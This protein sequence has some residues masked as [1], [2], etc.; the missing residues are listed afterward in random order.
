MHSSPPSAGKACCDSPNPKTQSRLRSRLH[1]TSPWPPPATGASAQSAAA[2]RCATAG[3]RRGG[4]CQPSL[5]GLPWPPPL[6]RRGVGAAA[7]GAVARGVLAAAPAPAS[8]AAAAARL[9]LRVLTVAVAVVVVHGAGVVGLRRGFLVVGAPAAPA[10][11]TSAPACARLGRGRGPLPGLAGLVHTQPGRR[12]EIHVAGRAG[13]VGAHRAEVPEDVVAAQGREGRRHARGE[14]QQGSHAPRA[15][16]VRLAEQPRQ[17]A[18][19]LLRRL[20][21]RRRGGLL[22][23]GVVRGPGG[24]LPPDLRRRRR[25]GRRPGR[26]RVRP[27]GRRPRAPG[28]LDGLVQVAALLQRPPEQRLVE[29]GVLRVRVGPGR[30]P[31]W[32][33]L[34]RTRSALGRVLLA[35]AV[36]HLRGLLLLPQLLGVNIVEALEQSLQVAVPHHLDRGLLQILEFLFFDLVLLLD[37]LHLLVGQAPQVHTEEVIVV[38]LLCILVPGSGALVH[39]WLGRA[40]IVTL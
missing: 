11:A 37:L 40:D 2:P 7:R 15:P 4:A 20:C 35:A 34:G 21:L 27:L 16:V 18:R 3:C 23:P 9:L 24:A 31:A 17:Q 6:L 22:P 33:L 38:C 32:G 12:P 26:H 28:G 19:P 5:R 13:T 10:A 29:F 30:C 36:G 39:L 1:F 25:G 8:A 14:A